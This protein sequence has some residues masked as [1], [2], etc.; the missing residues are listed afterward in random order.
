[1]LASK[2][3]VV[4]GATRALQKPLH[5]GPHLVADAA[6]PPPPL[7]PIT[8]PCYADVQGNAS[9]DKAALLATDAALLS[10][11]H[12]ALRA[13]GLQGSGL[14]GGQAQQVGA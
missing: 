9:S 12:A 3:T 8:A 6:P 14:G 13:A 5:P 4:G 7:A 1:M 10:L 11:A 2:Q